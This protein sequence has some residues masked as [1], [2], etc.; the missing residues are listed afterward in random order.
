MVTTEEAIQTGFA[1]HQAG[2]L[3][4]AE[5]IYRQVLSAHPRH[6][7]A[8][9]LIGLIAMQTGHHEAAVRH[10]ST[11]IQLEGGR[12]AYHV[13]L[14]EAYRALGQ[15]TNAR[16]CYEQAL[17]FEPNLAEARNCLGL[18]LEGCGDL[19]GA[20][21]CYRQ[22]LASRPN[23][24]DAHCNLGIGLFR[25]GDLPAALESFRRA[26]EVAPQYAKAHYNLALGLDA[27]GRVDEA[28]RSLEQAL[29]LEPNHV[30]AHCALGAILERQ[31]LPM[32]A[33]GHYRAAQRLQPKSVKAINGLGLIQQQQGNA[34]AALELYREAL[35]IDPRCAE[36]LYNWG[37]VLSQQGR[38]AEAAPKYQQAIAVQPTLA[39]AHYN[40]GTA[41]QQ[42]GQLDQAAQAYEQAVRLRPSM[43][44]AHNNLGNVRKAQGRTLEAIASYEGALAAEPDHAEA[45]NNLGL[46]LRDQG[47]WNEAQACFQRALRA[48]PAFAQAYSNL[49]ALLQERGE[50]ARALACYDKGLRLQSDFPEARYNRALIHL[51]QQDFARGWPDFDFREQLPQYARRRFDPPRWRGEPLAG[52]TLLVYAEQGLGDTLMFARYLPELRQQG[53]RVIF[54]AQSALVP[55]LV[56][57]GISD[58]VGA[59][60]E[61]PAFDL[62]VPLLSL[63]GLIHPTLE[64]LPG[65]ASY[66]LADRQRIERWRPRAARGGAFNVGIAW[67]GNREYALDRS[68]SISLGQFAPL[69]SVKG[70]RLISLQK[71]EG[72]E[73]LADVAGH[74]K[75]DVLEGLDAEGGAFMDTAAVMQSLDLVITSDTATAHLAGGLGVPVWVALSKYPDWRWFLER[76]GVP[77][78]RRHAA[79]PAA[80]RRRLVRAVPPNGQGAGPSVRRRRRTIMN[81]ALR[82]APT[83]LRSASRW[84]ARC[85]RRA[86]P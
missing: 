63:P 78:V 36:A 35:A 72:S 17:R 38:H 6:A 14:G 74:F 79:V 68:R 22:A 81:R 49:G 82:V 53:G 77:L 42:L 5:R 33:A 30:D 62:H 15:A 76:P 26:V 43:A 28:Q 56:A 31:G 58:V 51:I 23:F 8:L 61:L 12:P 29:E 52:R 50:W 47:Q 32:A 60:Q 57:S 16:A 7:D 24:A 45:L 48:R 44:M 80:E 69:A 55:L 54:E 21:A 9:H 73:Q 27:A 84:P 85:R 71:G 37:T 20:L 25:Q 40:L 83:G 41:L 70:V 3:A 59:G 13:N 67:Q 46:L 66:L 34:E 18:L 86:I 75:V 19:P 11:A 39:V 10:I 64:N 65:R 1:H 4:E 2:R